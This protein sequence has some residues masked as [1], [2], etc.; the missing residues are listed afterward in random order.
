MESKPAAS[1]QASRTQ[2]SLP[3]QRLLADKGCDAGHLR[4][5]LSER[6]TEAVIPNKENR[7]KIIYPFDAEAYWQRN[8][9]ERTFA[10]LKYF[11]RIAIHHDKP[12][13]NFASAVAICAILIW[14][15]H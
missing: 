12:A 6:G 11:H 9:I 1:D 13:S 3:S 4:R 10:R 2:V 15:A 8:V 14:G 5:F 7:R